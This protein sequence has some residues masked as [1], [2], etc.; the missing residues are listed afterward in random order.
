MTQ[1]AVSPTICL[2]SVRCSPTGDISTYSEGSATTRGKGCDSGSGRSATMS[3]Y[4]SGSYRRRGGAIG[5]T[6][7]VTLR[8]GKSSNDTGMSGTGGTGVIEM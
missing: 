1:R 6:G 3:R 7:G 2:E 4:T 5:M 8:T